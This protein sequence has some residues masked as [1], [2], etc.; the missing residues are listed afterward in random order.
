[1][2]EKDEVLAQC[3]SW[4]EKEQVAE[5]AHSAEAACVAVEK[6]KCKQEVAEQKQLEAAHKRASS[7][8]DVISS[9]VQVCARCLVKGPSLQSLLQGVGA[10][11][12]V[13]QVLSALRLVGVIPKLVIN[14][15]WT[16]WGVSGLLNPMANWMM[17]PVAL[18]LLIP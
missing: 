16:R 9:S 5:L 3:I 14:V 11:D 6:Q 2:Q 17:V 7:S 18:G 12:D 4:V 1:M 10:D 15:N 8:T 13:Y